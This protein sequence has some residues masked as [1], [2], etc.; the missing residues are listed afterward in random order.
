M[1]REALIWIDI[2]HP[3]Y[4]WE[5]KRIV[6][7]VNRENKYKTFITVREGL[8][9]PEICELLKY[10]NFIIIGKYGMTIEEKLIFD[11]MRMEK[12]YE[13]IHDLSRR[14]NNRICIGVD[15]ASIRVAYGLK[16][17]TICVN[18]TPKNVKL[19]RLTIPISDYL[20]TPRCCSDLFRK[21][22]VTK[23]TKMIDYD[24]IE[25]R[26]YITPELVQLRNCR[27]H[28][29]YMNI[30]I[31]DVE[32][33]SSYAI[34]SK[35]D[36]RKILKIIE[37]KV[38]NARVLLLVRYESD[39]HKYEEM[40]DKFSKVK[41]LIVA[42]KRPILLPYY[43]THVDL[44]IGSGGTI[45]RE[46]SLLGIPTISF[47]F[48]DEQM[49]YLHRRGFPNMYSRPSELPDMLIRVLNDLD[50]YSID[51]YTMLK[52]MESPI[53]PILELIHKLT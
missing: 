36:L 28:R 3:K 51:T 24:G 45:C 1:D 14:F 6:N 9:T 11:I 5:F 40:K 13:Y 49:R 8:S 42:P 32:Y 29:D 31:R 39:Y 21:M 17:C 25:E 48:W 33:L 53:E 22:Y 43:L 4:A 47:Y 52:D 12:L 41:I 30:V 50:R 2:V 38:E 26:A 10:R 7:T 46:A 37:S 35:I 19:C 20:V 18:D 23:F 34:S 44:V 15:A 16:F 27:K